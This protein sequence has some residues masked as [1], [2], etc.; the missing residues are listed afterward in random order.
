MSDLEKKE[1]EENKVQFGIFL[2]KR[3]LLKI[4][5]FLLS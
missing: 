1:V 3:K 4:T 5:K 2:K